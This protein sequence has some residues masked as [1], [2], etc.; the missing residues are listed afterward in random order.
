MTFTVSLP[1]EDR[2]RAHA[3]YRALGLPTPGESAEDGVPEPLVVSMGDGAQVMLIP[4]GGFNWVTGGQA[5]AGPDTVECRLSL[6]L[7]SPQEVDE[8]VA[9]AEEAGGTVIA[10]P[11]AQPWGYSATFSD[12]DGHLWQVL[13]P[14]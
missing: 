3:F 14:G 5:V 9:R 10:A 12:P 8:L 11:Q 7:S 4:I 13:V 6:D 2:V 1:T